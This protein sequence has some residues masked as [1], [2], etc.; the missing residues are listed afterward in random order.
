MS[1]WSYSSTDLATSEKDALRLELGDTDPQAWL[2]ADQ[3]YAY[4]ITQERNHWSAAARC[5]EMI[6]TLFMRRVDVKLGRAMQIAYSKTAEQY[7]NRARMLRMKAMGT[8]VP[9]VGAM[10]ASDYAAIAQN[11]NMIAESERVIEV[12][13]NENYGFVQR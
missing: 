11:S 2:L 3:E 9:Y 6:G 13:R 5:A 4:A 7:F 12:M 10:Y 1:T 8:V